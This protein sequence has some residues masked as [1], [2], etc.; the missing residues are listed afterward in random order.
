[1]PLL[2]TDIHQRARVAAP[3]YDTH[4]LQA[5]WQAMWLA[6]G[7]PH[8]R[9]ANAAFLAFCRKRAALHPLR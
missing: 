2:A 5:E 1:M 8:L 4:F 9:S 3:G 7:R 6:S